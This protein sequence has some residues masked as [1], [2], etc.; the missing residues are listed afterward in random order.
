[1]MFCYR[2]ILLLK[3]EISL[4]RENFYFSSQS[5]QIWWIIGSREVLKKYQKIFEKIPKCSK[6]CSPVC[7]LEPITD[8]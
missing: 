3:R 4:K 5:F 6:V 8:R 2:Y 7:I 1:M